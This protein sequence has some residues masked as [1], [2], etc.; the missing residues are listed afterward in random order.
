MHDSFETLL[1]RLP[2]KVLTRIDG[3]TYFGQARYLPNCKVYYFEAVR[4]GNAQ[5]VFGLPVDQ[6]EWIQT[7]GHPSD[8]DSKITEV[9]A[10]AGA[11]HHLKSVTLHL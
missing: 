2:A 8:P 10:Y 7:S 6:L 11:S 4:I 3:D 5:V 9:H 1:K